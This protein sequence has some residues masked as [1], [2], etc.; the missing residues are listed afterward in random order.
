[1][2]QTPGKWLG[3]TVAA[4]LLLGGASASASQS[5][6]TYNGGT[7]TQNFD[8]LPYNTG[9]AVVAPVVAPVI[10]STTYTL[11]TAPT[12][13]DLLNLGTGTVAGSNLT[14]WYAAAPSKNVYGAN[15]GSTTTGGIYSFGATNLTGGT[16]T[17]RALGIISTTTS[18]PGEVGVLLF[19]NTAND[20]NQIT[21]SYT[22]EFWHQGTA[23]KTLVFG[24]F[25]SAT[26]VSLPTSGQTAIAQLNSGGTAVG[27][28]TQ[29]T[30]SATPFATNSVSVTN[31]T[32]T[33][34]THGTYLWLTWTMDL[35]TGSGQGVAIDDLS[36]SFNA[37]GHT[38]PV[39][40]AF[41]PNQTYVAHNQTATLAPNATVTSGVANFN[42][43]NLTL[44]I[45]SGGVATEDQLAIANVGTGPGQIGVSGSN[46]T[47]NGNV[48]GTFTGGAYPAPLVVALNSNATPVAVQTLLRNITYK[49]TSATPT[50][51]IRTVQA[52]VDDGSGVTGSGSTPVSLTIAVVSGPTVAND[53]YTTVANT[54][55]TVSA[56]NGVFANDNGFGQPLQVIVN[57][58]PGH[59]TVSLNGA[60]GSFTYTP[61]NGFTGTDTFTYT[62][63]NAVQLF[64]TN[65]PPL[66]V[67]G[68]VTITA[69]GYGSSLC[70]VPGSPGGDEYY[71]L[72]DRGP[73]VG[74]P[75]GIKIEPITS[76]APAIGKFKMLPN[77][78]ALLESS[79][80]LKDP[81]GVPYTGHVNSTA[82]TGETIQDINGNVIPPDATGYDSEGLAAL[83]D[84][85][86]WVSDEYGPF[87]THF[88]ATGKQIARLSPYDSSLPQE[89][90]VRVPNK[91]MEGLTVTP[92]GTMLV[93]MM[94]NAL[95]QTDLTG[96]ASDPT[97]LVMNRIVTIS[98]VNFSVHEYMY[99]MESALGVSEITAVSNTTFLV[100]ERDGKYP[101][102]STKNL[103]TID[104][105]G[106]SDVGP[107]SALIGTSNFTYAATTAGGGFLIGGATLEAFL[108][109]GGTPLS[110]ANALIALTGAGL[111]PVTKTSPPA[112]NV[113]GLLTTL[114]SAGRFFS[115]DKVE[116]VAVLNNGHKVLISNDSDFGITDSVSV[117]PP[118]ALTV[119]TSPTTGV[120]DD[121]E[122]LMVNLDQLPT[123]PVTATVT[124]TV[125]PLTFNAVSA[126][127]VT[128]SDVI[129]WTRVP[130]AVPAAV[131]A[132]VSPDAN[133]GTFVTA[134]GT[135]DPTQDNT[136]KVNP[137]G[138]NAGTR[139]Y[140]RFVG[141]NGEFSNIGTFKTAYAPT[142]KAAVHFAFSGDCDGQWRPFPSV[143]DIGSQ[144]L[145]F[146]EFCGDT[147]Y[148]NAVSPAFG[149]AP[150]SPIVVA[151]EVNLA[152]CI[153]GLRRKY[154]ENITP[155]TTNGNASLKNFFASQ[156]N[157]TLLDNHELCSNLGKGAYQCGGAPNPG[158][159]AV[160]YDPTSGASDINLAGPFTNKT[161]EF[162]GCQQA[163]RNY[164]PI[165][166][167][168]VSAPTDP[169]SDGT[170]QMYL[171]QQWGKNMIFIHTDDRSYADIRLSVTT[172][173][174]AD[175]PQ[176]TRLGAT[177]LAWLESTLLAAQTAGTPWKIV[178]V[179]DPIDQIAPPGVTL[180]GPNTNLTLTDGSKSWSGGYR[181]ERN[182]LMTFIVNN[183]ITNVVFLATDDHTNRANELLYYPD[184]VNAPTV[185]ALVPTCF[186]IVCGPIG[187]SGPEKFPAHD[188]GTLQGLATGLVNAQ[189]AAG[190]N[191]CGLD[192][193]YPGLHDVVREFDA[194]ADTTRS[195]VD[196][197]SPDTF[198]YATLD[199]SP[200]GKTLTVTTLGINSF[201]PNLFTEAS[202][203]GPVRQI[204]SFQVD[205]N[206]GPVATL[207]AP[208]ATGAQNISIPLSITAALTNPQFPQTITV[209][210]TGV[211]AT[212]TLSAGANAG[213]GVWN[214][215]SAQLTGL[216]IKSTAA[217]SIPLTATATV[218]DGGGYAIGMVSTPFTV[219]V[220]ANA[221]PVASNQSITVTGTAAFAG[222]LVA[223]DAESEALTF[224]IVTNGTK[225]TAAI[226]NTSTGA[227]TYTATAAV[228]TSTTDTFT[229]K[230]TDANGTS[231][232]ATVTVTILPTVTPPT[233]T[234]TTTGTITS[235]NSVSFDATGS[236]PNSVFYVWDFGDGTLGF[237][238]KPTHVYTAAGNYTVTV[239][240]YNAQGIAGTPA[241]MTVTVVA[242]VPPSIN[243]SAFTG[244][245]GKSGKVTLKLNVNLPTGTAAGTSVTVKIGS[246]SATFSPVTAGK[247]AH[248]KAGT[249]KVTGQSLAFV[250]KTDATSIF[251]SVPTSGSKTVNITVN[252]T[253]FV[254]TPTFTTKGANTSF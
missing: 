138:L 204:L 25:N 123:A 133:F 197:F 70:P 21:L 64:K 187:A 52:T 30:D 142:V 192:P 171:A 58:T 66:G 176:R 80:T 68:G 28:A 205:A 10:N 186:S 126:G 29:S 153:A 93:G 121:G 108:S 59:G 43:G 202:V 82:A 23:A 49:N 161:A 221:A 137:T 86:F 101:P 131:T 206:P 140:Y 73:N 118:Y 251:G 195:A 184:P 198:N 78:T 127:D 34:W 6:F 17:D 9:G 99:L 134:S 252:S 227:F 88:D 196:F 164:E 47:S 232:T 233:G 228:A 79:I 199:I 56:A 253:N 247:V 189:K 91:G 174:R 3:L 114:D 54:P 37:T 135:I 16:T 245:F 248:T 226:T 18:N 63:S 148:E 165:R 147:M 208:N 191:P 116:G 139:Y 132:Q 96:A 103:Y 151:P 11:P 223:T 124:I 85:T 136:V 238:L 22:T 4:A 168:V 144:Q 234:V 100:D 12:S 200:N 15:G 48:I 50:L 104:I 107:S 36:V 241:T 212:S 219:T 61:A 235:G 210:I 97:K 175:N 110:K 102:T 40:A 146:F 250:L 77:G 55:L 95:Q 207:T 67:V 181:A 225:G 178:V 31:Q 46:V 220:S 72:T 60:D 180:S 236:S 74:G 65:L 216:S 38:S 24:Y 237:G 231:N 1:M 254:A 249:L 7:Y 120:Q 13:Y 8:G 92:D 75:G 129:L 125:A 173:P 193:A 94:Q 39:V 201:N 141:P 117:A 14:G 185:Q 166:E 109:P 209:Q 188:F 159:G 76:F 113:V 150:A 211:P 149:T 81:T 190:V 172:S 162:M 222:T 83:S 218:L 145:D 90:A 119:K 71:G 239:T 106:A 112:L 57:S 20:Y 203:T 115:H 33:T 154:L 170:Q 84:G 42:T 152:Q 177:Q 130:Q 27:G 53:A 169:R 157:Y 213:G 5:F 163:F 45:T 2:R 215:T 41:S 51:G 155:V 240:P 160:N 217:A 224:A 229:F 244:K 182:A 105:T 87:I 246:L 44:S 69:G 194:A 167:H 98:L 230:A 111:A 214:L 122:F 183:K 62:V 35:N 19:N 242:A 89:L 158:A 179:S 143:A 32:I 156:A 243:A 26:A 128:A